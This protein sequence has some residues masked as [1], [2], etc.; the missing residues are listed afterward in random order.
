MNENDVEEMALLIGLGI[1]IY[2]FLL[3][4]YVIIRLGVL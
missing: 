2:W 1:L 4:Y 3:H